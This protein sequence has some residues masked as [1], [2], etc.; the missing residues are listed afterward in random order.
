MLIVTT[1][2]FFPTFEN[3]DHKNN[4]TSTFNKK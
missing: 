3:N 4:T 1:K 2:A